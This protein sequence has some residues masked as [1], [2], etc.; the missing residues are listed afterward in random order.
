[1]SKHV[2]QLQLFVKHVYRQNLELNICTFGSIIL[3]FVDI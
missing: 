1:M 3:P 2:V